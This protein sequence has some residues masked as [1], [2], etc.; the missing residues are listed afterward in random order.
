M[1]A[2]TRPDLILILPWNLATEISEQLAYTSEWGAQLVTPIP[3][4]DRLCSGDGSR[5]ASGG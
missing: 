5:G 4:R 3:K 1:I 2:E